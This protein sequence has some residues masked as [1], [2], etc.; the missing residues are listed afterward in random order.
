MQYPVFHFYNASISECIFSK[1]STKFFI[2]PKLSDGFMSSSLMADIW[3]SSA[4]IDDFLRSEGL[5]ALTGARSGSWDFSLFK[6]C[7]GNPLCC[8]FRSAALSWD[9]LCL[10]G[11]F[12]P[13]YCSYSLASLSYSASLSLFVDKL[14]NMSLPWVCL[15]LEDICWMISGLDGCSSDGVFCCG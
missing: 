8:F 5:A 6:G 11:S 15:V 12:T 7:L 1:V 9:P 3:N 10:A 4:W 2:F 14:A 13:L